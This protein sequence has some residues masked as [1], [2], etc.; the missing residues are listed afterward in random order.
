MVNS[1]LLSEKL[2]KR[3]IYN[4]K[5][6][7]NPS[8]LK[9]LFVNYRFLHLII[10][11]S[12]VT[13]SILKTNISF[14]INRRKKNVNTN[15]YTRQT[16][17]FILKWNNLNTVNSNLLAEKHTLRAISNEKLDQ[18]PSD[19][20]SM[21]SVSFQFTLLLNQQSNSESAKN[22]RYFN[23]EHLISTKSF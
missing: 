3:A 19:L 16:S 8:Y 20:K 18:S 2:T 15:F 7:Q 12:Y 13:L 22:R 6:D 5:L 11:C 23:I 17:L 4:D 9:S 21:I 1:N 10:C 14:S